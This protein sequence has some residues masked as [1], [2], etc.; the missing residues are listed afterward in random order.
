[1][2]RSNLSL[3]VLSRNRQL[4]ENKVKFMKSA[5]IIAGG[6]GLRL[7]PLTQ[8]VPKTLVDIGNH[9]ILYW[10]VKWLKRH[11]IDHLVIGVAYKKEKIF[12]FIRQNDGFGIK[13]DFSEHTVEG[14]TAEAF[15]RAMRFVD[16]DNFIAMNS[17]EIT[18]LDIRRFEEKHLLAD[19]IIT[20]ATAKYRAK[21]SA[22]KIDGDGFV[23]SFVYGPEVPSFDVSTGIYIFNKRIK[24]MI[25]ENGSIEN[26]VF[27]NATS[28]HNVLACPLLPGETW[29][30]VNNLKEL[31]EAEDFVRREYGEL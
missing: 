27:V 8:D 19:P 28:S 15:R 1:M 25:P 16:D 23:R 26:T 7:M 6:A 24:E 4:K 3:I 10:I 30:T 18:N 2:V 13:V 5:I 20:M 21:L 17:D 11:G 12:D 31:K 29:V 14:G 22:V 9:P